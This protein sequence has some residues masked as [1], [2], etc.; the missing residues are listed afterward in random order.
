MEPAVGGGKKKRGLG[1]FELGGA[2]E[3]AVHQVGASGEHSTVEVGGDVV[4]ALSMMGSVASI[5]GRDFSESM[6]CLLPVWSP[7][8]CDDALDM[9][10][11]GAFTR[12][13]QLVTKCL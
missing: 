10:G 5:M 7:G 9:C 3:H 2:G 11:A 12:T 4:D 8:R 1:A 6:S 13:A